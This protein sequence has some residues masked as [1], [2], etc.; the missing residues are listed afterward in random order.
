M[1]PDNT[2]TYNSDI[3]SLAGTIFLWIMWPSTLPFT[4]L[5]LFIFHSGFNAAVAPTEDGQI[6]AV[7]NTFLAICSSTMA[8]FFVSRLVTENKLKKKNFPRVKFFFFFFFVHPQ[9]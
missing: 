4:F 9:V 7:I 5:K 2:S 3:F 6:R 1:H 8:A